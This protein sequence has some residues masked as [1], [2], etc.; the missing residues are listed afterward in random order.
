[1][2]RR[3]TLWKALIEDLVEDFLHFFFPAYINQIDLER[4]VT[5][6]D[7][8]LEQIMPEAETKRRHADK[9]F[10]A[11]LKDG[12]EQWF[13]VHVEVQ[14]YPDNHFAF[15]MYQYYYRILDR[16]GKPVT[17]IAIY[18]D[19]KRAYHATAYK[20]DFLGTELIYRFQSFVL[21]DY[22][23]EELRASGNP[24]GLALEA[25]RLALDPRAK[26]DD[27][28]MVS[29]LELI[30]H[31][32][33]RG[34]SKAKIRRLYNFI[35]MYISFQNS[36]NT[37]KFER[38]VR[39]ITKSRKPMGLE[40]AILKEVREQ[41]IEQGIGQEK[42]LAILRAYENGIA[43]EMIAKIVDLPLAQVESVIA[44]HEKGDLPN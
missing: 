10:K 40:E 39:E 5:F 28:L 24:F 4:G 3:D 23:A 6:L 18:T 38:Q 36:E 43:T 11:W 25:A 37:L 27:Q 41:G 44:D 15:R 17:A 14:G 13:L 21:A 29:K 26:N 2:I 16:Y 30:R 42:Q 9:L 20:A 8:D 12:Q 31:L 19:N 32:L 35:N 22:T 33:V 34:L 1:M 7:K